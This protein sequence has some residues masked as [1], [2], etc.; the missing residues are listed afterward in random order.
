MS[1]L[2]PE[3]FGECKR[4]L[5]KVWAGVRLRVTAS[6]SPGLLEVK[7]FLKLASVSNDSASNDGR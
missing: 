4:L 1:L 7:E 6:W 2:L 3:G 5:S